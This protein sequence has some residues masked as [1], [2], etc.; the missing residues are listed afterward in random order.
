MGSQPPENIKTMKTLNSTIASA[1]LGFALCNLGYSQASP[2]RPDDANSA[3]EQATPPKDHIMMTNGK[4]MVIKDGKTSEM[5]K[6]MTLEDGTKVMKD[7]SVVT[8]DGQAV[9][10]GEDDL[11]LFNGRM[12]KRE[13][14]M[15]KDGKMIVVKYGKTTPLEKQIT[16]ENGT[17]VTP[18]GTITLKDGKTSMVG[19]TDMILMDGTMAKVPQAPGG[20]RNTN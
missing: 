14:L 11:L 3:A 15:L 20:P 19:E 1:C 6:S 7:G 13:H 9:K 5:E 17:K 8:K 10:M 16:L 12:T 18:D 4:M 2:N